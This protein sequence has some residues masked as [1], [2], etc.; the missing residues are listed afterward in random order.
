MKKYVKV[1][2]KHTSSESNYVNG[3]YQKIYF[4][5]YC[6]ICGVRHPD[7]CVNGLCEEE[8]FPNGDYC[9][10]C[11]LSMQKQGFAEKDPIELKAENFV[12]SLL[13]EAKR[14]YNTKNTKLALLASYA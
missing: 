4:H 12:N 13:S 9:W 6:D 11:Q 7:A 3:K 1:K 10:N 14:L 2:G 5:F 8:G